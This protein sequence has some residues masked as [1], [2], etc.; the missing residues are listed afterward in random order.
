MKREA[1]EELIK[2]PGEVIHEKVLRQ[3]NFLGLRLIFL[4]AKIVELILFFVKMLESARSSRL[5]GS[6][7]GLIILN[8]IELFAQILFHLKKKSRSAQ[9]WQSLTSVVCWLKVFVVCI[10]VKVFLIYLRIIPYK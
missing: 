8:W 2:H 6:A 5:S 10:M 1:L 3:N 4:T 9:N 7:K